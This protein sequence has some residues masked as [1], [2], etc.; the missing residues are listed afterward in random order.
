MNIRHLKI[1][2]TVCEHNNMTRAARSLYL[3]QPSVSQAISELEN[4]YGTKLF[5]RL[6]HR[7][8]ITLAGE[9]LLSYARYILNLT[10]QVRK[11][12]AELGTAGTLRIGASL[13]IGSYLLPELVTEFGREMPAVEIFTVVDNTDV[14]ERMILQDEIDIGLVEGPMRSPDIIEEKI[15]TD[16][17]V[18]IVSPQNPIS[19][20]AELAIAD[21]SNLKF[22]V[23]ESGS[24][25]R[26]IFESA[27]QE[28]GVKWRLAGWHHNTETIKR[29]VKANLGVAVVPQISI[30]EDVKKGWFV[31]LN[32]Q[33]LD[34][35]RTFNFIYHRQKFLTPAMKNFLSLRHS[36]GKI[37]SAKEA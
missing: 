37:T 21:L 8:H 36:L 18:F 34:L 15:Q 32:V 3:S 2:V 16:R 19:K 12:L 9:R 31:P 22:I 35:T 24:G 11:D 10:E 1:F 6:N 30:E 29:A 26:L 27:M 7:L 28:A 20:K 4:F 13:T 5:E 33:G 17:L 14:I 23:R 25:T